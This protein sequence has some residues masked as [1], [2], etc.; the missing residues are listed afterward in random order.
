VEGEGVVRDWSEGEDERDEQRSIAANESHN[1]H[2]ESDRRDDEV[3]WCDIREESQGG[4]E[5]HLA[6][7]RERQRDRGREEVKRTRKETKTYEARWDEVEEA[8]GEAGVEGQ[9]HEWGRDEGTGSGDNG[10]TSSA[11]AETIIALAR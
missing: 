9:D 5:V 6:R 7:L 11:K 10:P 1:E 4:T 2:E 3:C 8:A